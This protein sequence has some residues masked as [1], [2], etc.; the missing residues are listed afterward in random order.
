M[1]ILH[2]HLKM[3]R[4]GKR[5]IYHPLTH[6][7][8]ER[9][10]ISRRT[11]LYVKEYGPHSNV[12]W[13]ILRESVK[14]LFFAALLS[15]VGGLTLEYVKTLFI[16]LV[17][18]V[19]LFPALNDMIG[20][21]GI[22]IS[23]RLSAS[24]HSGTIQGEWREY[25]E[26][27]KLFLQMLLVSI[28]TAFLGALVALVLSSFSDYTLTLGVAL[29]VFLISILDIVILVSCLFVVSIHAG[30]YLYRKG[31]DPDNFLIPITTSIADF[32]NMLLLALLVTVFF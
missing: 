12:P 1:K 27:R 4:K 30:L 21:Y 10:G 28:M 32:G 22:I 8:R 6:T 20:D 14:V 7:I 25:P 24:L 2:K 23:S 26:L 29:K 9:Y 15:S 19:I 11:L 5:H 17:P 18:L 16:S 31:K 13:T 3:L